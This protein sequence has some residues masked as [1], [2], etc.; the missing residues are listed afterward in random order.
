MLKITVHESVVVAASPEAVWDYTQDWRRRR[1]WDG[2]VSEVLELVEAPRRHVK[3]RFAGGMVFD[4]EYKLND[5]PRMTSLAMV[6]GTSSWVTGGGGSWRYEA[7]GDGTEWVQT[8]TLV[9]ADRFPMRLLRP[10]LAVSLGWSTRR[11]MRKAAR[12]IERAARG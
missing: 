8:N 7:R 2:S 6:N 9:L 3:A 1:E 10:L 4:V 12:K 11:A 5:R